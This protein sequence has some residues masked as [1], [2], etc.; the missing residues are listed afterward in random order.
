MNDKS[1]KH[2]FKISIDSFSLLSSKK[3]ISK[4]IFMFQLTRDLQG[5]KILFMDLNNR[6]IVERKKGAE[7]LCLTSH[8][9]GV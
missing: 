1:S 9:D 2:K 4:T 6:P 3:L 7:V 8:V 5:K